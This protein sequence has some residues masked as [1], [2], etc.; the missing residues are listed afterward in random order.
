MRKAVHIPIFIFIS[1]SI[2]L[3]RPYVLL[4]ARPYPIR[5]KGYVTDIA[6]IITPTD[7]NNL[8]LM[9]KEL[10]EKTTAQ[11][12]IVTI[13]TTSPDDIEM[14]AVNL[15]EKWGIGQKDKDNG[16]LLLVAVEDR[17]LR[18]ET[19]YG[20]EGA[21]PDVVCNRIIQEVI[22]PEF[23]AGR[24]SQGI[25]R[26]ASAIIYL[27]AKEYGVEI[28]DR[29]ISQLPPLPAKRSPLSVL[30]EFI[31][32]FVILLLFISMRMGLLGWF[33][34]L[35]TGHR[36]GGFWYGGGFGGASGG[37]SGGFGGFGGGLSGGGGASGSW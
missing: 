29:N 36:R 13:K 27:V 1:L 37:F 18:I 4:S 14:Y 33:L 9:A 22:I 31:F 21:L 8:E 10:E 12:A 32:T 35:S 26:G 16:V 2:F 25:F 24:Y 15:F 6:H 5:P 11:I 34:L 23:K 28:A 3:A 30:L 7:K 17:R 20:L 19:G